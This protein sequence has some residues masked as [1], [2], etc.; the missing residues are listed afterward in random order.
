MFGP[1][2]VHLFTETTTCVWCLGFLVMWILVLYGGKGDTFH[3]NAC[4][5]CFDGIAI[6][7]LAMAIAEILK[8]HAQNKSI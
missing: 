7:L 4:D 1:Y 5:L 8:L 2:W 6:I 3:L